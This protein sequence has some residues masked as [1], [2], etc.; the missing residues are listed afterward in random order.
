LIP[1]ST[2]LV[3]IFPTLAPLALL[4]LDDLATQ[5]ISRTHVTRLF[6]NLYRAH[7]TTLDDISPLFD[8][9]IA[10][11]TSHPWHRQEGR[12]PRTLQEILTLQSSVRILHTHFSLPNASVKQR[13]LLRILLHLFLERVLQ[14]HAQNASYNMQET[15]THWGKHIVQATVA[16]TDGSACKD[17]TRAGFGINFSGLPTCN[18][19]SRTPGHQTIARAEAYGVL[20]ALIMVQSNIDLSIFCDREPLVNQLNRFISIHSQDYDLHYLPE[21]SLVLRILGEIR[22]RPGHTSII[23][24]KAHAQDRDRPLHTTS[25]PETI[26]HQSQNKVAHQLAKDSLQLAMSNT[27]VPTEIC[28]LAPVTVLLP[29]AIIQSDSGVIFESNPLKIYQE[30]YASELSLHYH[31]RGSWH[32]HLFTDSVWRDASTSILLSKPDIKAKKFLVQVLGRTLPTF[33]RLNKIRQPFIQINGVSYA[34]VMFRNVQNTFYLTVLS[35]ILIEYK[36][37][38][39]SSL[40]VAQNASTVFPLTYFATQSQTFFS[41]PRLLLNATFPLVSFLAVSTH[42]CVQ[43]YLTTLPLKH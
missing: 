30:A 14:P 38:L 39:T 35:F 5:G 10:R 19:K 7:I 2:S 15:S 41:T 17:G 26:H 43:S 31:L 22:G 32:T 24:V 28:T 42:G 20:T 8:A 4:H 3:I 13:K 37:V 27:L 1:R 25:A 36:S 11:P 21:R 18:V 29:P 33:H 9:P 16:Y 34:R 12:A 6:S 23:Y 40:L